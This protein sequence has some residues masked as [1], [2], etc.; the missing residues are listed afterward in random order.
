MCCSFSDTEWS[1]ACLS[2][3]MG[4]LGLRSTKQHSPA[5]FLSSQLSCRELCRSLDPHYS[6]DQVDTLENMNAALIDY[7]N[8]VNQDHRLEVISEPPPRQQVLSQ[9]IDD[10]ILNEIKEVKKLDILLCEEYVVDSNVDTKDDTKESKE[11]DEVVS[12]MDI[13]S[14][15]S[16]S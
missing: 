10:H 2:T 9:A 11:V 13:M 16:N 14:L 1:L 7:N 4:G 6:Q 5:A 3:K 15:T 8:K 12:I